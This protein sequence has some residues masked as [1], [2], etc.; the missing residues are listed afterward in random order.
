VSPN[1][2]R[3]RRTA[4]GRSRAAAAFYDYIWWRE[5][6]ADERDGGE[7]AGERDDA[8]DERGGE[9]RWGPTRGGD[10]RVR[11]RFEREQVGKGDDGERGTGRRGEIGTRV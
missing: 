6:Y 10:A 7:R 5:R 1:A 4:V 8:G 11:V 9:T 3:R 2:R